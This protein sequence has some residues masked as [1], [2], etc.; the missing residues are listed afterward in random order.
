MNLPKVRHFGKEFVQSP[1]LGLSQEELA[2]RCG[3]HRN[4]VGLI[5]RGERTPN[6]ETL[7]AL[8]TGLGTKPSRLIGQL[9]RQLAMEPRDRRERPLSAS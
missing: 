7:I 8:A 6:I 1:P 4:A 9:E 2:D 5:E 3:L